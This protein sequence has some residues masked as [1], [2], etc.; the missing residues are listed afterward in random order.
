MPNDIVL[1]VVIVIVCGVDVAIVMSKSNILNY[2]I[3]SYC[4]SYHWQCGRAFIVSVDQL[5]HKMN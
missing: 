4:S 3:Y 5:T 1:H 2:S